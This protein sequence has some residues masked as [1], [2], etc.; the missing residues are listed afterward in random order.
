MGAYQALPPT[1]AR[2]HPRFR[3]PTTS[4]IAMGVASIAFFIGLALI[5]SNILADSA[6]AVGA[7]H[8]LL[9][10]ND[11]L[12]VSVVLPAWPWFVV[13]GLHRSNRTAAAGWPHAAGGVRQDPVRRLQP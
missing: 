12:R 8:R 11:G 7:A 9:L 5:S 3:T 4:T 13:Q 10:R 1:F 6:S 2:I